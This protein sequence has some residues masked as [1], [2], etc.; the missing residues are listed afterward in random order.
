MGQKNFAQRAQ[1]SI[2]SKPVGECLLCGL[3]W[4]WFGQV[5]RVA[6]LPLDF[7]AWFLPGWDES[8]YSLWL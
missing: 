2:G 3:E 7:P 8:F 4:V 1:W 6:G 5:Q